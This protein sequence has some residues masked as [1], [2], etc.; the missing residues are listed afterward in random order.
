MQMWSQKH[1]LSHVT[2]YLYFKYSITKCPSHQM[3]MTTLGSIT[4]SILNSVS[5]VRHKMKESWGGRIAAIKSRNKIFVIFSLLLLSKGR[6]GYVVPPY[7]W[8][9]D[10]KNI[11]INVC[12]WETSHLPLPKPNINTYFLLWEK[13]EVW[14]V[15]GGQ[16]PRN[17]HWFITIFSGQG[18]GM[19]WYKEKSIRKVAIQEEKKCQTLHFLLL[20]FGG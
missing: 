18:K 19:P 7:L 20:I 3:A 12:F 17:I 6:T 9:I 1:L 14:G 8:A 13:C 10:C 11:W 16:F 15:V 4:C 5:I 2:R